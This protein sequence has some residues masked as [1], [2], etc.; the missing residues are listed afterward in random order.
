MIRAAD[1]ST[2]RADLQIQIHAGG[3]SGI[4]TDSVESGIEDRLEMYE[5]VHYDWGA[6]KGTTKQDTVT[7]VD[8]RRK[9]LL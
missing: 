6:N 1:I 8:R 4:D 7:S 5:V 9:S 3:F 2:V